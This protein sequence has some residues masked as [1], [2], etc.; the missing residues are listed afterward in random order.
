MAGLAAGILIL[1]SESAIKSK[2]FFILV[3]PPRAHP[4]KA[5]KTAG[6][7]LKM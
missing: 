5:G 3:I 6:V 1:I 4:L 7:Q 2:L